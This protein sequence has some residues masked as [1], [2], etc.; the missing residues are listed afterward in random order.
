MEYVEVVGTFD[1]TVTISAFDNSLMVDDLS[2]AN[3]DTLKPK[4]HKEPNPQLAHFTSYASTQDQNIVLWPCG[5][6]D[7]TIVDLN[8]MEY[9]VVASFFTGDDLGYLPINLKS[10]LN[11]R[12]VLGLSMLKVSKDYVLT[13]WNK[14]KGEEQIVTTRSIKTL[15]PNCKQ[16][17][18]STESRFPGGQQ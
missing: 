18:S 8:K 3:I 12:K 4:G 14:V 6:S 2:M 13:Y 17:L 1:K 10:A 9:D 11:G 5:N 16:Y 15:D 7:L